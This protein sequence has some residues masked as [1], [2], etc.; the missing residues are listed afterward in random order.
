MATTA[1]ELLIGKADFAGLRDISANLDETSIQPYILEAQRSD[2]V[3]LLGETLYY[4]FWQHIG[5]DAE[6]TIY[7]DLLN[8]TVYRNTQ[9]Q[10]VQ[11]YG[12][13]PYLVYRT[14]CRYLN[15]SQVR[16]TRAGAVSKRTDESEYIDPI[17]LDRLR[18]ESDS[19]AELYKQSIIRF[20][21][22][23]RTVYPLWPYMGGCT[24]NRTTRK[25]IR[26]HSVARRDY[27]DY[28]RYDSTPNYHESQIIINNIYEGG[29]SNGYVGP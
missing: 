21:N 1:I 3:S 15:K 10:S 5:G 18:T 9:G 13:K 20:L 23:A 22:N 25:G 7:L 16:M 8:G 26:L 2:L 29:G 6:Y 17:V 27:T 12:I 19:F 11:F 28:Y 24:D 4:D 14:Y